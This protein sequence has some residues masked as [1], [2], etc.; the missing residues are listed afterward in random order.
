MVNKPYQSDRRV[1]T[2][3]MRSLHGKCL[4]WCQVRRTGCLFP[5]NWLIACFTGCFQPELLELAIERVT[6]DAEFAGDL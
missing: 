6:P 1:F 4:D 3:K 2:I 5:R